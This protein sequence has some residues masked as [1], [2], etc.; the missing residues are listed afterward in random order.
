M[1]ELQM[2]LKTF[3]KAEKTISQA[4]QVSIWLSLLIE[5]TQR[6]LDTCWMYSKQTEERDREKQTYSAKYLWEG[7]K[8]NLACISGKKERGIKRKRK[9]AKRKKIDE[10]KGIEDDR[11][12][13]QTESE[14]TTDIQI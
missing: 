4:L 7:R 14:I 13:M 6:I 1:A 2:K 5:C 9:N 11:V 10:A 8:N 12:S 3:E